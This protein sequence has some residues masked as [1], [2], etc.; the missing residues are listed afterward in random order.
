M[1]RASSDYSFLEDEGTFLGISLGYDYC[2]EHEWGIKGLKQI[3]GIPEP[4]KKNAGIKAR[5]ITTVP[6]SLKFKRDGNGAVL[7]TAHRDWSANG[8][9]YTD[10]LP[11]DLDN[12]VSKLKSDIKWEKERVERDPSR[13]GKDPMISAWAEGS[14][15]IAVYGKQ[16][17]D[18]LEFLYEQ[19]QKKNVAITRLNIS[20]DNPFANA[21]LSIVIVDRL[22][23]YALDALYE[24]DMDHYKLEDY[25]AKIGLTKLKEKHR[26][27]YKENKYFMAASPKWITHS[28]DETLK[29]AKKRWKTKYDILIWINYSDDD[30]HYGWHRYE[31][32]KEWLTTP[33]V[34]LTEVLEKNKIT[35]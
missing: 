8:E 34:K 4:K 10:K 12:Y 25:C 30:D 32:I 20:G 24:G 13:K 15:G 23:Q 26:S 9:A 29:E 17:A 31:D 16:F 2:A 33:K 28:D 27:G 35:V 21:S 18:W 11:R 19:F 22:P 7:W 14:F 5:T 6:K 1:R 3:F